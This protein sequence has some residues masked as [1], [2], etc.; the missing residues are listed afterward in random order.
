VFLPFL[1]L[2]SILITSLRSPVGVSTIEYSKLAAQMRFE[3]K[4]HRHVFVAVASTVVIM[5]TEQEFYTYISK[6]LSYFYMHMDKF[7]IY[8]KTLALHITPGFAVKCAYSNRNI[9]C[10]SL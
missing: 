4:R 10:K 8:W 3:L 5:G 9:Q 6:K 7:R 2:S 1:L